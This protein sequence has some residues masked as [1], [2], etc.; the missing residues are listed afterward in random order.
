[1]STRVQA[2]LPASAA[3][4]T[5]NDTTKL[6]SAL[7]SPTSFLVARRL[8]V[9]GQSGDRTRPVARAR[10]RE[11]TRTQPI[12]VGAMIGCGSVPLGTL[13]PWL[14]AGRGE[15]WRQRH[16]HCASVWS[17]LVATSPPRT[18]KMKLPRWM[19]GGAVQQFLSNAWL[20]EERS[21]VTGDAVE[22]ETGTVER[23]RRTK[24]DLVRV[25]DIISPTGRAQPEV[26]AAAE[27]AAPVS[28]APGIP[29]V[30][31]ELQRMNERI[32]PA[33]QVGLVAPT[34]NFVAAS[35]QFAQR[36]IL[37]EQV[38]ASH[39]DLGRV[40]IAETGGPA[41]PSPTVHF[42]Q[43]ALALVHRTRLP[44]VLLRMEHDDRLQGADLTHAS[45]ALESGDLIFSSSTALGDGLMLLDAYLAP[46]Y[47]AMSPFV[48]AFGAIRGSGTIV[49]NL[50]RPVSGTFPAALEPLHLLPGRGPS[51][52]VDAPPLPTRA[53][54]AAV[55]WWGT[56]LNNFLAVLSDP[57]VFADAGGT[58][59]PIKHVHAVLSVEQVFRR[60]AAIQQLRR[61]AEAQQVLFFSVLD[62]LGRLTN[63]LLTQLCDLRVAQATLAEL[64]KGLSADVAAVL[65]PAAERGVN[66]LEA[67]QEGFFIRRQTGKGAVEFEESDG[68]TTALDPV[69][70]ASEYIRLLR[71]ATHGHGSNRP[72]RK[73]TTNALLAH[74]TGAIPDDL[75]LLAYVYLLDLLVNHDRLR[76]TLYHGGD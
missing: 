59:V 66:A 23:V 15:R 69:D 45:A 54:P 6:V 63:R 40:S 50:G 25:T 49:F 68:T 16:C 56:R 4:D 47:G 65:L 30:E 18:V 11:A 28:L 53:G 39:A 37:L 2:R 52:I 29:G 31:Q 75:P 74:H 1:M 58:Y 73:T 34:F 20:I 57:A 5:T 55:H 51:G 7:H 24:P 26:L 42:V 9:A 27:N 36:E 48:W 14:C 46:L 41:F 10:P 22:V 64:R 71:N 44:A 19:W 43:R 61:S 38:R 3:F 67:L 60:T 62:T 35:V 12:L 33:G 72:D 32:A 17:Q 70:A 76:R 21:S 8:G 13:P